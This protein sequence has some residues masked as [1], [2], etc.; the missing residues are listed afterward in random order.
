MQKVFEVL[1]EIESTS[2][3][4]E[5]KR[6]LAENYNNELLKGI[7]LYTYNARWRYG[8]G[9][10]SIKS[11]DRLQKELELAKPNG[12]AQNVLFGKPNI[13][14]SEYDNI[15]DLLDE[16]IKHPY[17]SQVDVKRVNDFLAQQDQEAYYWYTKCILKDLK[18]G[19][20]TSSIN[21]IYTG[22]IPVF[23]VMLAHPYADH[24]K[25]V[26]GKIAF[27]IEQKLNGYRFVVYHHPDGSVQFFTRNGVELFNF[28]ELE[29]EFKYAVEPQAITM[30]YDGE[31]QCGFS[32][33]ETQKFM[34]REEDKKG[35]TYNVFDVMTID[36]WED[37]TSNDGLFDRSDSLD[38]Y[39]T[40]KLVHIR[41]VPVLY[42]GHDI[43]KI[44]EW[45]AYAKK[46][47]WEGI[48]IKFNTQYVRKRIWWMLKLKEMQEIDLICT[49]V[50]PGKAGG[51]FEH[52]LGSITV[53]FNGVDVDLS[54]FNDKDREYYFKNPDQIIG[55]TVTVQYFEETI[56]ENGK[57]SLQFPQFVGVRT[58]K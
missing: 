47:K 17:G 28:S 45:F 21:E 34:M 27:Q 36:E 52:T 39:L 32:F 22:L 14:K 58:D 37:Q 11:Y 53:D 4:N 20:N 57:P 18:I 24:V 25:K 8:V 23:E 56:N 38:S 9:Q 29:A 16:L 44:Q 1:R 15:F 33:N 51:K 46:M 26:D 5:K 30:V 35:V 40:E 41:R 12:V 54:G 2:S 10:K 3:R 7:L 13:V 55:K 31:A 48:M 43:S 19:C 49:G 50:N 42:R 6:I